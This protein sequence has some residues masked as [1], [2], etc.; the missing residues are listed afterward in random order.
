MP[1]KQE[2]RA[3]LS[4]NTRNQGCNGRAWRLVETPG[5]DPI[6]TLQFSDVLDHTHVIQHPIALMAALE[7]SK[8]S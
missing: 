1:K 5:C 6:P 3:I 4:E 7:I 8:V 2:G